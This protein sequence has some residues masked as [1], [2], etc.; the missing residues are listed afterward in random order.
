M[1]KVAVDILMD[2]QKIFRAPIYRAHRV[3]I[4]A[5]ARLSFCYQYS[6]YYQLAVKELIA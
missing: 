2:S 3:V 5:M 1:G 4:F 6:D